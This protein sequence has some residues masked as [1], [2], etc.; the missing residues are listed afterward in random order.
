MGGLDIGEFQNL[1]KRYDKN[2]DDK[3]FLSN[4]KQAC[5]SLI[6]PLVG[7]VLHWE[8]DEPSEFKTEVS[9][10]GKRIDYV[11]CDQGISQFIVEA[12][13][14]SR[15]IYDSEEMYGQAI[16]YGYGKQR[17]FAI[18]TNFRQLVILACRIKA[19]KAREAELAR[20]DLL[21]ASPK[22]MELL[23]CFEKGFWISSGRQNPLFAM[24][25][26]HK[27]SIPLDEQLL[28]DLKEWRSSLLSNIKAHPGHNKY[29][30]EDE[31][32]FMHVEEE[33]QRMINRLIFICFCED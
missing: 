10:A 14:P 24:L 20:I 22:D 18:L 6:V 31:H 2:K 11:V 25:G 12:K 29:D 3:A 32:E 13:A 30:F 16:S 21:H 23:G 5:Q 26:S 8:T 28:E 17:D 19:R 9:Q 7:K 4:E 15:D 1:L 27:P 33:V